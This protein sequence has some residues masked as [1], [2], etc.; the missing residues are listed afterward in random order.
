MITG[1]I[2]KWKNLLVAMLCSGILVGAYVGNGIL[3]I[4]SEIEKLGKE[5]G[6]Q[7]IGNMKILNDPWSDP[8]IQIYLIHHVFWAILCFTVL[9]LIFY[10]GIEY[11][12]KKRNKIIE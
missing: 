8:G 6:G 3:H 11:W 9:T 7:E 12:K 10:F 4:F 1:M 5:I 2:E